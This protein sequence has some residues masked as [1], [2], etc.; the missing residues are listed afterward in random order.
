MV[1]NKEMI[2]RH[3]FSILLQNV[4]FMKVH[5][6]QVGLKLS[7]THQLLVYADDVNLLSDNID[8]I[9]K[10]HGNLIEVTKQVGLEVKHREY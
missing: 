10:K 2:Y 5:E 8:T 3:C 7:W 9:K 4:P 6:N 1:L